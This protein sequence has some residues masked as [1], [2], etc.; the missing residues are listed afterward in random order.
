M[1][2]EKPPAG[3]MAADDV[4]IWI[5]A[6]EMPDERVAVLGN[7]LDEAERARAARFYFERDRRRFIVSHGALRGILSNYVQDDPRAIRFR[8]GPRGKP[9]LAGNPDP[10][11]RFNLAHSG[12]CAL[13]A[14][15]RHREIG[16]DIEMIK[17][18]RATQDI[19]HRFFSPYEVGVLHS[20]PEQERT[21]AF[22]RLWARKE[23]YLK[24][25][26]EGL[27]LPLDSFDITLAPHDPPALLQTRH[28]PADA[29]R[30]TL[31]DVPV[32]PGYAA[33]VAAEGED[34]HLRLRIWA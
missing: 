33:A 32:A 8:H 15:A 5:C 29:A 25:R 14:V 23:A 16:V 4:H 21:A 9:Y 28:D 12:E 1:I 27:G 18:Q 24:A 26:G 19:A 3:A 22:Y 7:L 2:G 13:V 6:L 30:W 34:W 11:A 31:Q 17:E 10:A 20:L